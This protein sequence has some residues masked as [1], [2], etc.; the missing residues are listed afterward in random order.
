MATIYFLEP[1]AFLSLITGFVLLACSII[2]FEFRNNTKAS[3]FLLFAAGIFMCS[4]SALLDPFL[5]NWDEQ[6]HALVAKNFLK[7]PFIP[8]L[9]DHPLLEYDPA[10]W[11]SNHIWLHKQPLFLWQIAL[12]L[13]LFGLN[14]FAV[15]IP[16]VLMMSIIPLMIYRIG[17]LSLNERTAYYGA[18]LFASAFFVHELCTGLP[19]SDHN[20]IAFLFYIA[21]SIWAWVE[22]EASGKK[23]WLVLIGLFSGCA[24]LVKWL[25]GL[26]VFSG[27]GISILGDKQKR[28]CLRSY[29][30]PALSLVACVIVFLPWQLYISKAFPAESSAEYALNTKH[31]FEVV[32]GHGGDAFYYFDNLRKVYGDGQLVPFVILIS[33]IFLYRQISENKFRI[34]FFSY[35][36]IVYL[37]FSLAATKMIAFC[38]IVSPFIFLSLAALI[39]DILGLVKEK[40]FKRAAFQKGFMVLTLLLI[41]WGNLNLYKIAYKH[42]L[43]V[44]PNDNDKRADKIRDAAFIKSLATIL[45]SPDYVIFNCKE[46]KNIGIMFYTD[47]IAYDK[48]L[49]YNTYLQLKKQN[50]KLAVIDNGKLPDYILN[51]PAVVRIQAPDPT[52][53]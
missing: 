4:F 34:A 41:C 50:I 48:P 28:A 24:V 27:W 15:R 23:Y 30:D 29:I 8:A 18:L 21:A 51:D 45:P 53:Y 16:S 32:E 25:T 7:H 3:L 38:F 33:F 22:Y 26:L 5:N 13:K 39:K 17:K 20:D 47:F 40:L 6:F 2:S 19:P 11:I 46:E 10:S 42:T 31:F 37:F 36:I 35:I 12:S 49:E 44:K 52:W 43:E 14:E 9:Y 1:N